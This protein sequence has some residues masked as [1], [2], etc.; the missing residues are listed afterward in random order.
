MNTI[1]RYLLIMIACASILLGIQIPSFVDQYEKRLDAH[2]IEAENN[3]RGYQDIAD[4]FYGG[5]I[6]SLLDK[7]ER[8]LDETFKAEAQPI[9][10][11]F[12]RYRR[13]AK[14]K[15]SL[16]TGLPGKIAFIITQGDKE[17]I[18]E[19]YTSYS[20]TVPLN[21]AAVAC[22]FMV[23]AVMVLLVELIRIAVLKLIHMRSFKA[24]ATR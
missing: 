19:T 17:L 1:Y 2:L 11:I 18:N 16:D 7:H 15:L 24:Q 6:A 9:K 20:F 22:G 5:S 12:E 21:G 23:M 14:A 3:L 4:K 10:N 8:S 13:F